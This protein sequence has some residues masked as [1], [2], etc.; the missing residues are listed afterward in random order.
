MHPARV[1][2]LFRMGAERRRNVGL[3][4]LACACAFWI[5]AAWQVFTP[6]GSTY[7]AIDCPA[8]VNSEPRDLYF[9]DAP[10]GEHVDTAHDKALQCASDRSWPRPLAALVVS[11]PL[12]AV[13]TG[14]VT[15]GTVSMRLRVLEEDLERARKDTAA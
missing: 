9:E 15:A 8:P 13:G 3:G 1:E 4:L 2:Q 7:N 6:Y 11:V 14:L 10:D 12:S 5:Y